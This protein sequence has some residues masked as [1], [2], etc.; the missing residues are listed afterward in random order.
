MPVFY[1]SLKDGCCLVCLIDNLMYLFSICVIFAKKIVNVHNS[2]SA[3]R[4]FCLYKLIAAWD[5]QLKLV[6]I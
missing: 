1:C 3:Q 5:K 2:I 4:F 6:E